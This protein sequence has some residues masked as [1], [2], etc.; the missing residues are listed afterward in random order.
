M[1]HDSELTTPLETELGTY[2]FDPTGI[3]ICQSK[4]PLRTLENVKANIA[5][6]KKFSGNKKVCLLIFLSP[7]G[8]PDKATRQYVASE[9]PN[10]YKAMA[11]VSSSGLGK[12]IMNII[13]RFN[14]PGIPMKTFSNE[15]D[16]REWLMQYL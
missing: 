1:T 3:L 16:A 11:M 5:A 10:V 8:K 15:K 2:H 9:L 13:F 12:I 4:P 6:V 14:A 7:S